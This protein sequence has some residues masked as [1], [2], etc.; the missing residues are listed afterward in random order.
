MSGSFGMGKSESR[1][2]PS[3]VWNA[4]AP[5]LQDLFSRAQGV[6][7][8]NPSGMTNQ[9]QQSALP[10]Y[11]QQLQGGY[12]SNFANN[13]YLSAMASGQMQN[14]NL[15]GAINAGLNTINQNYT[16]NIIPGIKT[17]AAL[18]NVTGGSRQGIAQGLAA[19][20]TNQQATDFVNNMLSQNYGQTLQSQLGAL[21]QMGSAYGMMDQNVMQGLSGLPQMMNL[22]YMP[23][24][25]YWANQFY[26]LQQY[27]SILGGP[28]V[29]GG[30]SRSD[31]YQFD[32]SGGR[33]S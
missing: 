9:M 28:T 27:A 14:Q 23:E 26:P 25:A 17:D 24:Q 20:R 19:S 13:P 33:A 2:D 32:M 3:S 31:A 4:Q 18:S 12:S 30:G 10:A 5:Y 16:D 29:L 1:S 11:L 21:G 6:M 7:N 8:A 15:Q 22:G